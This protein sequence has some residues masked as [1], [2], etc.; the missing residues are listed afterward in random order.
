MNRPFSEANVAAGSYALVH[1]VN[2]LHVA[3]DLA[4][5]LG[6]IRAA[7]QPTGALVISECVRPFPHQPIYVEFIFNLLEAFREPVLDP[8]FR[9][10]GGFLTPEQWTAA[11]T[12]NGFRDVRI[13]PDVA[14]IRDDYP[15]FVVASIVASPA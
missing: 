3:S 12:A 6:E 1:G 10:N 13:V 5:T 11:L 7:L 8:V 14:A 2:T 15:S 4:F 9:P